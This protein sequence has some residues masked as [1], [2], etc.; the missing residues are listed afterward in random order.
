MEFMCDVANRGDTV[1]LLFSSI[2]AAPVIPRE[3]DAYRE[4]LGIMI[5]VGV[6]RLEEWRRI[7]HD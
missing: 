2:K 3:G 1:F 7:H 4:E 5:F 6:H